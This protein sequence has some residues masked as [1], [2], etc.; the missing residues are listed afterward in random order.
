MR[1][2][3]MR[4][5]RWPVEEDLR[6]HRDVMLSMG[7]GGA[8]VEM[9]TL[10]Q[11]LR[12]SHAVSLRNQ[13]AVTRRQRADRARIARALRQWRALGLSNA[14]VRRVFEAVVAENEVAREV[15]DWPTE[16]Q[17]RER[18]RK[19]ATLARQLAAIVRPSPRMTAEL[20]VLYM[21]QGAADAAERLAHL[22]RDL[23]LLGVLH[24]QVA[25]RKPAQARRKAA[26]HIAETIARVTGWQPSDSQTSAFCRAVEAGILAADVTQVVKGQRRPASA[27]SAI[28]AYM[29]S[30]AGG[31][32]GPRQ[33]D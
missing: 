28:H 1:Q 10:Q 19:V 22:P 25:R 8:E 15:A 21:R 14:L 7:F 3:G 31:A 13:R 12:D 17:E 6:R 29:R 33:M 27:R 32:A 16:E 26:T 5:K 4:L 18:A 11:S 23:M 30:I 9:V 2:D 20:H 24:E